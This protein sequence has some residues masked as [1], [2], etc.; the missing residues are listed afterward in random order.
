MRIFLLLNSLLPCLS[1]SLREAL[2]TH[3]P[4]DHTDSTW[5]P[6][7]ECERQGICDDYSSYDTEDTDSLTENPEIV[8]PE[9]NEED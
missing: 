4:E 9:E 7:I 6:G 5:Y 2:P 3:W 1:L 8:R